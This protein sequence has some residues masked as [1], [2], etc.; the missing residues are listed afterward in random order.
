[1]RNESDNYIWE[2]HYLNPET[3]GE[4]VA[5]ADD[6]RDLRTSINHLRECGFIVTEK[7]RIPYWLGL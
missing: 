2:I 4:G 3:G 5:H 6:W 1:M 7:K